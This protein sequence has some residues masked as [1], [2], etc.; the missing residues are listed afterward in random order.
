MKVRIVLVGVVL[1]SALVTA[2]SSAAAQGPAPIIGGGS[3]FAGLEMEQWR[4]DV[5]K[6]PYNLKVDYTSAGSG[7][8]RTKYLTGELDY[9]V[10][11][12]P[13][14][15]SDDG[16]RASSKRNSFVYVPVSAGGL[17]FMYNLTG[18]DGQPIRNLQL[19]ARNVC[20][21]FSE[22]MF[23]DDPEIAAENPG[24]PLPHNPVR[25]TIRSDS[26]G[27][28][29]VF[30]QFC[31]ARAPD[32][33]GAYIALSKSPQYGTAPSPSFEFSNGEPTSNW[34]QGIPISNDSAF[35][36]DGV[37]N[38]VAS[39]QGADHVTYVAFGFAK[40]R[41]FPVVSVK[42]TA[43][44]Y[45]QPEPDNVSTALAYATGREDGT[46][47]LD[48]V[49]ADPKA[50]FPST[51]SY[52]LA[53]TAGFDS[54]KGITLATFLYYSV[55]KGQSFAVRLGYARLSDVLVRLALSKASQ[56]PGAPAP[57]TD[58]GGAPPPPREIDLGGA[59]GS[60]VG[61]ANASGAAGNRDPGGRTGVR[62]SG[63]SGSAATAGVGAGGAGE[64]AVAAGGET[65]V[66]GDGSTE[67][68][69]GQDTL[70]ITDLPDATASTKSI[71]SVTDTISNADTLW[72]FLLGFCLIGLGLGL[73]PSASARIRPHDD[74]RLVDA[75]V[76]R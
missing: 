72:Y 54:S 16:I 8:G 22:E 48:Y 21:L 59:A 57:P 51:Y 20:R 27:E 38:A 61:A 2:T 64:A 50:Y 37:A 47:K 70:D 39:P 67:V 53:Q 41:G 25:S 69:L 42:N 34:P 6:N 26:S 4:A 19:N 10:T 3:S 45:L 32:V 30:S 43:G 63:S 46:F 23:W 28:S 5:A 66:P 9:G 49:T 75:K 1:A 44:V 68:A 40:V 56:I 33:W 29:Y 71:A 74:S 7:F 58:L 15:R 73:G 12:I 76:P 36:S 17:G 31:I 55:T 24:L 60:G 62:G 14:Q 18:T 52:V 13:M 35:A 11:D 65:V